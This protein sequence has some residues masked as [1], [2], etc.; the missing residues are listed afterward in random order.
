MIEQYFFSKG[1]FNIA[2]K[3]LLSLDI[4]LEWREL[5]KRGV[6]I[7]VAIESKVEVLCKKS[8]HVS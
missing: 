2:D 1:L 8:K 5:L 3:V 4:L 6:P 7:S